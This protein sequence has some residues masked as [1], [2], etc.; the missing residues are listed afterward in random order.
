MSAVLESPEIENSPAIF[1]DALRVR[2]ELYRWTI[3]QYQ[4]M[5]EQ[6][7][8]TSE[9]RVELLEGLVVCKMTNNPRHSEVIEQLTDRLGQVVPAGWRVRVHLPIQSGRSQPEPDF[10]IVKINRVRGRHPSGADVLL[11]IEVADSSIAIDREKAAIY[12]RAGI[13][14]Y[15]IIN[16]PEMRVE[17]YDRV[18]PIAGE[19]ESIQ[20]HHEGELMSL[21][22]PA[23]V[24]FELSVQ[25][26]LSNS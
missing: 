1:E 19:Y 6:G 22:S 3:E 17:A 7:V 14:A 8:L 13:P 16:L 20:I 24:Y 18:N 11:V 25:D 12:A 9:D 4:C 26:V 10:S 21:R 5:V 2:A 23:G 15:W